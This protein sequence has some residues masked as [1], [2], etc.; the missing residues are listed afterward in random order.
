M[1]FYVLFDYN[2]LKSLII[3]KKLNRAS[4]EY[5]GSLN[6]EYYLITN[7]LYDKYWQSKDGKI[8]DLD[9]KL[10]ILDFNEKTKLYDSFVGRK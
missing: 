1:S 8:Y 9:K 5:L 4:Y 3:L 7:F 2:F 10:V 6:D